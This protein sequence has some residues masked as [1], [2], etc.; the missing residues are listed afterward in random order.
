MNQ[1]K[2]GTFIRK[3]RMEKGLTQ[4]ELGNKVGVTDRAISK[5]E[6]GRGSPD[7][8]LLI[9]LSKALDVNVLELLSGERIEDENEAIIDVIRCEKNKMLFWKKLCFVIM[10]FFLLILIIS[11][12]MGIILPQKY[13]KNNYNIMTV[14]SASMEPI[15]KVGDVIAYK[16]NDINKV[17]ENNFIVFY[18]TFNESDFNFITVHRVIKIMY[19]EQGNINLITRGD[20]NSTEDEKFV[21]KENYLGIYSHK[22]NNLTGF[23]VR[24]NLFLSKSLLFFLIL[25]IIGITYLDLLH[26]LHLKK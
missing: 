20:N 17:K 22:L 9:L 2:M 8:S 19:D 5:W 13:L 1:E 23:F 25:G 11:F 7:I 6:N 21:T 10:N 24:N 15:L 26:I 4:V 18:Y 16:N 3:I 14:S 12:I